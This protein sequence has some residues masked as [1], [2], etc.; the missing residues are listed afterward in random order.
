M[1]RVVP[2]MALLYILGGVAILLQNWQEVP[3]A[4]ALIV[5]SAFSPTAAAGAL[6]EPP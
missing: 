2:V 3:G 4:L 6:R 5:R 1:E